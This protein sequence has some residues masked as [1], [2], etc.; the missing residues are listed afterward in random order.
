MAK[1]ILTLRAR[2]SYD[3]LPEERYHFPSRY[4]AEARK[5][6]GDEI[7][8]YEPGRLDDQDS[9]RQGLQAYFARARISAI[10]PDQRRPNHFYAHISNYV[11]FA[12]P[13][14]FK[15]GDHYFEKKLVNADGTQNQLAFRNPVRVL[16]DD[17]FELIWQAGTAIALEPIAQSQDSAII[18]L[19]EDPEPFERR[20]VPQTINRAVR[21]A[22]FA[23][24]IRREYDATC[25]VTGLRIINGGGRAEIEAAHIQPVEHNG[26]DSPRNGIALCRTAHWM[27]DRGLLALTNDGRF[28][29]NVNKVPEAAR[30]MLRQDGKLILPKKEDFRPHPRFVDWHR[31]NVYLPKLRGDGT[32]T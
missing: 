12:R 27:F 24:A 8:Y 26:P 11:L 7:I 23:F 21:D 28:D 18:G 31:T 15:A 16:D 30:R 3:D 25:A 13:V 2:P 14:P 29:V 32:T 6:E 19:G 17:E 22:V 10:T 1:A 4:L 5:A 9:R 20:I